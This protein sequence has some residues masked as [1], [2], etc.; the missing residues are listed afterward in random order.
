MQR[1]RGRETQPIN[2]HSPEAGITIN[3]VHAPH[4]SVLVVVWPAQRWVGRGPWWI[5]ECKFRNSETQK[6][7]K[8]ANSEVQKFMKPDEQKFRS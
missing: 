5:R 7:I 3:H 6:C 2:M 1:L 8:P 4:S